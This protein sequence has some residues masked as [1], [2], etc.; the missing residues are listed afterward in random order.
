MERRAIGTGTG[1][2]LT[3]SEVSRHP[4]FTSEEADMKSLSL[5][6]FSEEARN[7]LGWRDLK[8]P[9]P[10]RSEGRAS[11][12]GRGGRRARPGRRE[13]GDR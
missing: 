1:G 12:G 4:S 11:G 13:R 6:L 2:L 3:L 7:K 9:A 8:A 10:E 5:K